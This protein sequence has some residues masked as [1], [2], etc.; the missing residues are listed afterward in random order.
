M[1]KI[2][3]SLKRQFGVKDTTSADGLKVWFEQGEEGTHKRPRSDQQDGDRAPAPTN[4]LQAFLSM[5]EGERGCKIEK[6]EGHVTWLQDLKA[7]YEA[8]MGHGFVKNVDVFHA[9]GFRASKGRVNVCKSCK[10]IPRGGGC[11][12]AYNPANRTK[13]NVIYDMEMA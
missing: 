2:L 12:S 10:L 13:K 7:A 6:V 3:A 9:F 8:C 1:A 5:E 11:C 4:L